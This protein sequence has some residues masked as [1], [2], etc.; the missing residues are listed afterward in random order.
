MS[1]GVSPVVAAVLLIAIAVIASITVWYWVSPYTAKPPIAENIQKN[2]VI[3][4]VYKNSSKDGCIALDIKNAGGASIRGLVLEVRDYTTGALVDSNTTW[5]SDSALVSYWNFDGNSNDA[6]N[7]NNGTVNASTY[8]ASGKFNGAYDF[9]GINSSIDIPPSVTLNVGTGHTSAMWARWSSG[10]GT[11]LNR[12]PQYF[13]SGFYWTYF[14]GSS[15]ITY[16][17]SNGTNYYYPTW[18]FAFGTT[19]HHIVFT[20]EGETINSFVDGISLGS[21]PA[22]SIFAVGNNITYI[23]A[24]QRTSAFFNGTIDDVAMFNRSLSATEVSNLYHSGQYSLGNTPKTAYVNLS[25]ELAPGSSYVYNIS[26][27]GDASNQV[28][29]PIGTYLLRVSTYSSS[30]GGISDSRFTCA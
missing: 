20:K 2:Y 15:G 22:P 25:I 21:T 17:Y 13:G 28:S 12:K 5:L 6:K 8:N 26:T 16:Q 14:Q 24:Y 29:V 18:Y 19:W 7:L 11:L 23:G 4:A 27:L 3:T 1:S 10:S 9:N 30:L